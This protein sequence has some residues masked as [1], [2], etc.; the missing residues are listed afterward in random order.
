MRVWLKA[1]TTGECR[2]KLLPEQLPSGWVLDAESGDWLREVNS[3]EELMAV[4]EPLA[5]GQRLTVAV[6]GERRNRGR[7]ELELGVEY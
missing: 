1:F 4:L 5:E 6:I 7:V 3:L 2:Y